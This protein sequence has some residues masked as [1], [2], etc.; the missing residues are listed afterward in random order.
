ML[1]LIV[2]TY[3]IDSEFRISYQDFRK[4]DSINI[5]SNQVE[6]PNDLE[7]LVSRLADGASLSNPD[8]FHNEVLQLSNEMGY[9]KERLSQLR[10]SE[11][12]RLSVDIVGN[13]LEYFDV[14]KDDEFIRKNGEHLPVD[15]YFY[16]GKGDCNRYANLTIA[17]YNLLKSINSDPSVRNVYLTRNFGGNGGFHAW[18]S[19]VV[20]ISP[21]QIFVSHIDPTY[22][23]SIGK[24]EA[25]SEHVNP[26]HFEFSALYWMGRYRQSNQIIDDLL[27][28]ETNN[29]EKAELLSE[30]ASNYE[31]LGEHSKAASD[32]ETAARLVESKR[33]K[34]LWFRNASW[35]HLELGDHSKIFG[36]IQQSKEEDLEDQTFY[37]PILATGVK[38]ARQI[39]RKDL[40][41]AYLHELLTNYP[42]DVYAREFQ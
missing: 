21:N 30:R 24:L 8:R 2:R 41:K 34:S 4:I 11:L 28:T 33:L 6:I 32:Y 13:R 42:T 35:E 20:A 40:E 38:S 7:S 14:D 16:I 9:S 19:V 23:D 29:N 15:S 17:T 36:I 31:N 1:D 37:P 3:E 18:V 5:P 12:I 10:P 26:D 25:D 39:G 27:T 22:Y